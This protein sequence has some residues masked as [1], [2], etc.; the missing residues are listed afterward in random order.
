MDPPSVPTLC[1]TNGAGVTGLEWVFLIV[2]YTL[3]HRILF[4]NLHTLQ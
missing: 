2:V 1:D 4:R 3:V